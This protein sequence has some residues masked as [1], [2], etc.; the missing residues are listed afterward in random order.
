M[1]GEVNNS[2]HE[3]VISAECIYKKGERQRKRERNIVTAKPLERKKKQKNQNQ[4]HVYYTH[5]MTS[6]KKHGYVT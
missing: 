3:R 6:L 5:F 1:V 4:E 2:P